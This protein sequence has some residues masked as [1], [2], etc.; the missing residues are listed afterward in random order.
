LNFLGKSGIRF[1]EKTE[2]P[3]NITELIQSFIKGRIPVKK[4]KNLIIIKNKVIHK[5]L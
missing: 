5:I 3:E 2:I 4:D 1:D